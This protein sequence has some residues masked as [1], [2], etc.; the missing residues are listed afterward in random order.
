MSDTALLSVSYALVHQAAPLSRTT[1]NLS[2]GSFVAPTID[3]SEFSG[4]FGFGDSLADSGNAQI[5]SLAGGAPDPT[6]ASL[7][8]LEGRFSN[9]LNFVDLLH[10]DVTGGEPT[11]YLTSFDA[12]N[13]LGT[14]LSYP[15]EAQQGVN[16]AIGGARVITR[17]DLPPAQTALL[18]PD[19]EGQ[20]TSFLSNVD[21]GL[22]NDGPP[23]LSIEGQ[24]TPAE[25]IPDDALFVFNFGGNDVFD[26]LLANADL[27]VTPEELSAFTT[28]LAETY[29]LQLQR[30]LD[31]GAE[32]FL[33]AGV[34][35]AGIAPFAVNGFFGGNILLALGAVQPVADAANAALQQ[36]IS[37]L[38]DANP[39]ATFFFYETD[40][41]E[42]VLNPEEFGFDP[43]LL[44]VPFADA[45][46]A[47]GSTV[48]LDD[49]DDY[50]FI[51]GVHSTAAG[52]DL[53]YSQATSAT[54]DDVTVET[55]SVGTLDSE[56]LTG[57]AANDTI[58]ARAGDDTVSGGAGDDILGGAAGNDVLSGNQGDDLLVGG[59]GNDVLKGGIGDD[60]LSGNAGRDILFGGL[61]DDILNGGVGND[62]LFGQQGDDILDGDGGSDTLTGGGGS[63]TFVF[64]DFGRSS[65]D[66]ITD[67]DVTA[68]FIDLSGFGETELTSDDVTTL[69]ATAMDETGGARLRLGD[70]HDVVLEGVV[71]AALME[72]H[73][74][75][76]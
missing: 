10:A 8:Y 28:E 72:D 62:R 42:G 40:T 22:F 70:G 76:A 32:N 12:L 71:V 65:T 21:S 67:F 6:P 68:D 17:T 63:D 74:I 52:Q 34:P 24:A 51:D 66:T 31:A 44:T 15:A 43:N 23:D 16:Y 35:N 59:G 41:A 1:D 45:F 26:F 50:A 27:V 39:Q 49:I 14:T 36:V 5:L 54:T 73:F 46:T 57:T 7:G 11:D 47:E 55:L 37:E 64:T 19:L 61:G 30:M 25:P 69:L 20:V 56:T 33:I 58:Q 18:A 4:V 13:S 38:D 2:L 75:L 48:T 3:L 53:L 9:G 60:A 29:R